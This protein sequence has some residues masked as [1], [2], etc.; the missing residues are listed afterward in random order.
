[1]VG[2]NLQLGYVSFPHRNYQALPKTID[3][4]QDKSGKSWFL[5]VQLQANGGE[6]LAYLQ[7]LVLQI[8]LLGPKIPQKT[9]PTIVHMRY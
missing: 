1:M 5:K 7:G 6:Y 3:F 9:S 4:N 2:M 8:R